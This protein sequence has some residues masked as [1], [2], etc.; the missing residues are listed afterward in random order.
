MAQEQQY[1]CLRMNLSGPYTTPECGRGLNME[2]SGS[3]VSG[4][5]RR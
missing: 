1:L 2:E 5:L 4:N 3:I